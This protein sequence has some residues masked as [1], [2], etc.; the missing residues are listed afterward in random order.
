MVEQNVEGVLVI[1]SSPIAGKAKAG[2]WLILFWFFN[3]LLLNNMTV[4]KNLSLYEI[5]ADIHTISYSLGLMA[6][7]ILV[8]TLWM[9]LIILVYTLWLVI[10]ILLK[11][12][13]F[14][15]M[16]IL[17]FLLKIVGND[18]SVGYIINFQN[19]FSFVNENKEFNLALVLKF[20]EGQYK[21]I[22]YILL[23]EILFNYINNY[24]LY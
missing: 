17:I 2:T 5:S 20:L 18:P 9:A 14:Y 12:A 4:I 21:F 7:I 23:C 16:F 24:F 22:A 6:L 13:F 1:G 10:V 19:L 3:Y 11:S 8:Y 15:K